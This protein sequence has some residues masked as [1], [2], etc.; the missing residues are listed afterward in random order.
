MAV[1]LEVGDVEE[2][3]AG[4]ICPF[5]LMHTE[6]SVMFLACVGKRCELWSEVGS[7][8]DWS[9]DG[10]GGVVARQRPDNAGCAFRIIA[11]GTG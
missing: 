11:E 5:R 7:W 10:M 4:Q 2:G 6:T 1:E 9:Q 3:K 8:D